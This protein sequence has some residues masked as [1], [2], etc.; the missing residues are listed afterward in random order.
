MITRFPILLSFV[1]LLLACNDTPVQ[2]EASETKRTYNEIITQYEKVTP[3]NDTIALGFKLR[4]PEKNVQK[5]F[6]ELLTQRKL[7]SPVDLDLTIMRLNN[8]YRYKL[9]IDESTEFQTYISYGVAKDRL[10]SMTFWGQLNSESINATFARLLQWMTTKFGEPEFVKT[11]GSQNEHL[12]FD[13]YKQ[14]SLIQFSPS[15]FILEYNDLAA[16]MAEIRGQEMLSKDDSLKNQREFEK[17][18]D[19]IK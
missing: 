4:Q 5:K 14:T 7:K 6:S 9:M 10:T 3:K 8:V 17:A 16:I 19:D 12:W 18:K 2:S 15:I 1:A 11:E 13:G